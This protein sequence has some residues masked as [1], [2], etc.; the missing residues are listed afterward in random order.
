MA[1]FA[2]QR[3]EVYG[4]A[5]AVAQLT[6]DNR[7]RWADLPGELA[8]RLSRATLAVVAEIAAG[9]AQL[10]RAEQRRHYQAARGS[11]N[12]AMSCVEVAQLH[13][14]VPDDLQHALA[15]QLARVDGMLT[16]MVRR[17]TN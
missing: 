12:E 3:L 10:S 5:K 8:D 11:A 2:F 6:I 9:A 15:T 16:G 7:R 4:V 1:R 14:V 17:R 13:G